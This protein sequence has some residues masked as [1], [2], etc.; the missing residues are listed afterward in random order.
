[1]DI[2]RQQLYLGVVEGHPA[3][4]VHRHPGHDVDQVAFLGGHQV[5]AGF[6]GEALA[7]VGDLGGDPAGRRRVQLPVQGR[8]Q[9]VIRAERREDR[10]AGQRELQLAVDLDDRLDE[11]A[12]RDETAT[13]YL[14]GDHAVGLVRLAADELEGLSFEERQHHRLGDRVVAVR[15][16]QDPEG[17]L[18]GHVAEDDRVGLDL[19]R[20]AGE[21]Y[22]VEALLELDRQRLT[23]HGI[24]AVIDR[25]GG[26]GGEGDAGGGQQEENGGFHGVGIG[27][28]RGGFCQSLSKRLKAGALSGFLVRGITPR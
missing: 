1:M 6:P 15:L 10:F 20:R 12:A 2:A 4:V 18:T 19:R 27:W 21:G 3:L 7:Q 22:L 14:A 5:V 23:D 25:Q 11:G 17:R 26:V 28:M 16:F 24:A 13:D 9:D 8:L